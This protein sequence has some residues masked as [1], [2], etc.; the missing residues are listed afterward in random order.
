MRI[1]PVRD[2]SPVFRWVQDAC[3]PLVGF[4]EDSD[5]LAFG[6]LDP[7]LVIRRCHLVPGFHCSAPWVHR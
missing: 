6:F 7:S 2:P 1:Y 5:E 4:V 3:L